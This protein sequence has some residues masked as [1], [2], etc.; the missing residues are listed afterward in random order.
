MPEKETR[1]IIKM[2][3]GWIPDYEDKETIIDHVKPG[4]AR[5]LLLSP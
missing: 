5:L 3:P 2:F 1:Y 4:K